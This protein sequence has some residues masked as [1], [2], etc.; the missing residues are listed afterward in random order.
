[1]KERAATLPVNDP[2]NL[3]KAPHVL[4]QLIDVV[5]GTRQLSSPQQEQIGQHLATCIHC[6]VFVEMYLLKMIE[7]DKA[8]GNSAEPAQM[9]LHRLIHITHET[10]KEDMLAY[11]EVLTEQGEETANRRFPLFAGH[12]QTCQGCRSEVNALRSWLDQLE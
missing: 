4:A 10:F 7:Y 1:M 2:G 9:L 8:H 5:H 12:V 3:L 6:Q 11:V